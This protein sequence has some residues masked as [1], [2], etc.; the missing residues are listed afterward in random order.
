VLK[1]L[2]VLVL[3]QIPLTVLSFLPLWADLTITLVLTVAAVATPWRPFWRRE[4]HGGRTLRRGAVSPSQFCSDSAALRSLMHT[5]NSARLGQDAGNVTRS[6]RLRQLAN[7]VPS[8][9]VSGVD[10]NEIFAPAPGCAFAAVGLLASPSSAASCFTARQ[11]GP[12]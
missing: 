3:I 10:F 5:G 7:E 1:V 8:A 12:G 6:V 4:L 11:G 9:D 2:V